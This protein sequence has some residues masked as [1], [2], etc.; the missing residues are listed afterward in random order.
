MELTSETYKT[1]SGKTITRHLLTS[2]SG[3]T[4]SLNTRQLWLLVLLGV[5]ELGKYLKEEPDQE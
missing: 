2:D 1:I 3:N 4:Q 5:V